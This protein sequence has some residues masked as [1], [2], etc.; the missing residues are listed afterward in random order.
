MPIAPAAG[1]VA[2]LLFTL[3]APAADLTPAGLPIA[4]APSAGLAS[5]GSPSAGVAT[6]GLST[7]G[8]STG[9][10]SVAGPSTA[11]APAAGLSTGGASVAGLAAGVGAGVL[12]VARQGIAPDDG[13]AAAGAGTSGGSAADAAHVFV[14]RNRA[15]LIEALGGDALTNGQNATP[16][17]VLISGR[18]DLRKDDSGKALSCADFAD[19]A[20]SLEGFL[21]AYDPAVWGT[22]SKPTGVLEDARVR[23]A[24]RQSD[25][26]RINVGSNTTILGING[27]RLEH[28]SLLL[29]NVSNVIV[30]NL[31]VTDAADCFPAWDPTDGSAG[32]WNSLYDLV[33]LSGATNVWLDHNTFSD[34][35]NHDRDQPVH[36][37]RPYQVHDGASDIIRGS[38]LVTVSWNDYYD[39]DKT[40]LIGSTDTP[41]VDVGKLRVTVHHNRFG[42]V[43]QRAPRV[44]FG[45]VDVFNNLYRATDEEYVYSL[46]VGVESSIYAEN[47]YFRLSADVPPSDV[48]AYWKGTRITARG[49]LVQNSHRPAV[50]VD[51]VAA[52]NAAHDPDLTPDAGWTPALRTRLDPTAAVPALVNAGAGIRRIL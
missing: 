42:N 32:N 7:A 1:L 14:V 47:N 27:G 25:H 34:G 2:A 26:I 13:W 12:D 11:G 36:F 52:Y 21:A 49:T 18:I 4:D 48:I 38:D 20:Y 17:I 44:R 24:K 51:L 8:L 5:T 3:A 31:E 30:R 45:Q 28:G 39:H 23:S 6:T 40:M 46:G 22:A 35:N 19:P 37:G 43:I 15:E 10:A 50:P 16:K 41:G 9:G 33:S 29:T